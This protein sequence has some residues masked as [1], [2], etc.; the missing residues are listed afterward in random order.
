MQ[1]FRDEVDQHLERARIAPST[2]GMEAAGDPN[3]VFDLRRGR[4]PRPEIIDRV[5]QFMRE[6]QGAA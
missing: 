4:Q 2:F 6:P 1:A 5:R 3:F